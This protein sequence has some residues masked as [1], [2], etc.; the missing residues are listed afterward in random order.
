[1]AVQ[2]DQDARGAIRYQVLVKDLL[3][4]DSYAL[5]M[6]HRNSEH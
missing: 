5:Y 6:D 1:V 3:D 2:Y 4:E